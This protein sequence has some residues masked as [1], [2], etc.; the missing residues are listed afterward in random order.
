MEPSVALKNVSHRAKEKRRMGF[1]IGNCRRD[2][3]QR[4]H[5]TKEHKGNTKW[6]VP[7]TNI[8]TPRLKF[9][10]RRTKSENFKSEILN[11]TSAISKSDIVSIPFISKSWFRL[12][13][14]EHLRGISETTHYKT[15]G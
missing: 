3:P 6:E 14:S 12:C 7:K 10:M 4:Q 1:Q 5:G 13:Y 2:R 8:Q 11:Q 15:K 9:K